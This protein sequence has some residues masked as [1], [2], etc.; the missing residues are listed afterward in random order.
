MA[1]ISIDVNKLFLL[2]YIC[3]PERI[4]WFMEDAKRKT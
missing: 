3:R 1:E 2:F 4:N